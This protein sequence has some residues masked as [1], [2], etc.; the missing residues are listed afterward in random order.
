V[1]G[2]KI[3]QHLA[4]LLL[5]LLLGVISPGWVD[6][7]DV[8]PPVFLQG[9]REETSDAVESPQTSEQNGDPSATEPEPAAECPDAQ[10][11]LMSMILMIGNV[12]TVS[13]TATGSSTNTGHNSW[14]PGGSTGTDPT[15]PSE[16]PEPATW[17]LALV[18]SV[19]AGS[20]AWMCHW[21]KRTG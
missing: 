7:T 9:T 11:A 3:G 13:L 20:G 10:L 17:L 6:A 18:G 8:D 5:A 2:S 1:P 16:T 19:C 15:E 21:R 4:C 12:P 14:H